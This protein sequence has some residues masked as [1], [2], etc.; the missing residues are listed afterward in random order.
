MTT[1]AK[2]NRLIETKSNIRQKIISLGVDVP[3]NTPFKDYPSLIDQLGGAEFLE[4][5]TDQDLLQLLDL[6]RWLGTAE[7]EDHLYTDEEIRNVHDLLDKINNG[8]PEPEEELPELTEP[9]LMVTAGRTIYY[10]GET[11]NLDD[12]TIKVVYPN[13]TVTDVTELC[14]F[15]PTTPL[16]TA[17]K[18][19]T[20][21]CV[22][23]EITL[24]R[25]QPIKVHKVLEY[26]A[27]NGTQYIKTGVMPNNVSRIEVSFTP[28]Y[29]D[30]AW[31]AIFHTELSSSPW[32]GM[33]LRFNTAKKIDFGN[34]H[35][36][37]GAFVDAVIGTKYEVDCY[38][39][40]GHIII[41]GETYEMNPP[42]TMVN[43]EL[44]AFAS[45]VANSPNMYGHIQ[46]HYL[47]FYDLDDNLIRDYV[48]I[49]DFNGVACLRDLVSE[50]YVRNAG[51]GTFTAGPE[52]SVE[53]VG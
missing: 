11:F 18:Y 33:G 3:I 2:L 43:T 6:Y 27:S 42:G 46:L 5:T 23:N 37:G 10:P 7:Y 50:T 32:N 16:T 25:V 53:E 21:S 17:S 40:D 24:S 44:Y 14:T 22:V 28:L 15:I 9:Y 30:T 38:C 8:E 41:N 12:Y 36:S 35:G 52:I 51:S 39:T 1:Q 4:T 19:V 49:E 13:G 29:V 20:I 48:P 31:R 45:N 47:R 34:G 26:I